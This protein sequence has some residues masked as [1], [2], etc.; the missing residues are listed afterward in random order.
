MKELPRTDDSIMKIALSF[1]GANENLNILEVEY[2]R[3]D[4]ITVPQYVNYLSQV[5]LCIELGMKCILLNEDNIPK[6]HDIK[7]LYYKMPIVFREIFEKNPFPIKTIEKSLDII[8]NAFEDFR[9]MK[10]DH[11]DFFLEKSIFTT[12]Y[13]IIFSQVRRLQNFNFIIVLLEKI[14]DFYNFIYNCIDKKYFF[15]DITKKH[16]SLKKKNTELLEAIGK[17]NEERK[18][19]QGQLIYNP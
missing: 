16:F 8:K 3:N 15:K 9:Y 14:T 10:T 2:K 6:T 7:E 5:A 17:Y 12:D 18:K 1:F 4:I 19:I 11:L 13:K